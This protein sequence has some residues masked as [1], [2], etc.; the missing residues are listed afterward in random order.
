MRMTSKRR[1]DELKSFIALCFAVMEEPDLKEIANK[2]GLSLST[3]RRLSYGQLTLKTHFGTV[4]AMGYA[5]GLRLEL[6][7]TKARVAVC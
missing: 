7:P 1:L 4:Q 3:V 6:T 2:S 5:A